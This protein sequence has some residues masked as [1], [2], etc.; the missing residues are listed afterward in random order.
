MSLDWIIQNI[1]ARRIVLPVYDQEEIHVGF[2]ETIQPNRHVIHKMVAARNKVNKMFMDETPVTVETTKNWL[3]KS[4][5]PNP[6]Q[7]I[8]VVTTLDGIPSGTLGVSSID[9]DNGSCELSNVLRFG[10]ILPKGLMTAACQTL[11]DWALQLPGITSISS[12]VFEDNQR[13]IDV[14]LRCGYH[15][16]TIEG[17]KMRSPETCRIWDLAQWGEAPDRKLVVLEKRSPRA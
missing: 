11:T 13:A 1:K 5:L 3:E 2:L 4:V 16:K 12:R 7:M 8:F 15:I 10:S 17:L 6:R 9:A 14:Y